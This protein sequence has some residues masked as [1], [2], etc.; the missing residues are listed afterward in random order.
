M[1]WPDEAA[2]RAST[3]TGSAA[4]GPLRAAGT[5]ARSSVGL[6]E[7]TRAASPP[8]VSLLPEGE[9]SKPRPL[10]TTR[11]PMGPDDGATSVTM[12]RRPRIS[13]MGRAVSGPTSTV[14]GTVWPS[15]HGMSGTLTRTVSPRT[16]LGTTRS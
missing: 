8:M 7:K 12:G 2:P 3:T 14:T 15:V 1:T 4:G 5:A 6:A 16:S 13:A 9:A 11:W 10:M